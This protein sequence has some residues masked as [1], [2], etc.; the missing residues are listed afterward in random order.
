M[1]DQHETVHPLVRKL[2]TTTCLV[3]LLP[4]SMGALVTTLKAGMAFADWPSS[5]GQNML[6]YPWL[7]DFAGNTDKFVEHGHRLAGM[8]IGFV[9][10]ALAAAGWK[11]GPRWVRIF[12]TAVLVAVILQGLLGGARVVLDQQVLAMTHSIT[13]AAF[14]SLCVLFRLLCSSN[15]GRWT[16]SVDRRFSPAGAAVVVITPIAVLGQYFLGGLLRHLHMMLNEH[17]AGAAIAALFAGAAVFCLLRAE[18]GLLRRCGLVL[19]GSLCLQLLLGAG[20]YVTRFG[21][22]MIGY[23]ATAGSVSQAVVCSMHTVVGMFLL[24]SALASAVSVLKLYQAGCL[25]GLA[26]DLPAFTDRG[27]VA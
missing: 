2:A 24:S 16:S 10:I 26:V 27:T 12:V 21:L 9:S 25:Q 5:D 11:F 14:F 15:W 13:G 1:S 23:V 4:I 8:L 22:P 18:N 17:L 6:L 3:A 19:C 20:S 7:S